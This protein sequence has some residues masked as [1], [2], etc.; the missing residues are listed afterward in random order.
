MDMRYACER[1]NKND[2]L[3]ESMAIKLIQK[4]S[5]LKMHFGEAIIKQ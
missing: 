1:F 5:A 4:C 2:A 3:K